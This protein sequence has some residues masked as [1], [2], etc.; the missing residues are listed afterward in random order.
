MYLRQVESHFGVTVCRIGIDAPSDPRRDDLAR[1]QAEAALDPR[2][3][4]AASLH[5]AELTSSEFER[6]H[7]RT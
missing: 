2:V 5:R 6:R 7:L 4:S 3:G 1:R